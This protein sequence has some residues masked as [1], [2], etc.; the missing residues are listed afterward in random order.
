MP[1]FQSPCCS[2]PEVK[3]FSICM[4]GHET[5]A[6]IA[7]YPRV[8]ST[9]KTQREALRIVKRGLARLVWTTMMRDLK[10]HNCDTIAA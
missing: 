2:T 5:Q 8:T 4:M 10:T 1:L 9:G 6:F 7:H 3:D